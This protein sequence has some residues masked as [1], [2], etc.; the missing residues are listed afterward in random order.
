MA[1][2]LLDKVIGN[3]T[4]GDESTVNSPTE[5]KEGVLRARDCLNEFLNVLNEIEKH[6]SWGDI[7]GSE[8]TQDA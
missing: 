3:P 5:E 1:A 2:A 7:T 8:A 4:I 6:Y